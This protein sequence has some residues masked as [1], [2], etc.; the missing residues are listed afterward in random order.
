MLQP[1]SWG[2]SDCSMFADVVQSLTGFD[3][4]ADV[5]GY[6][7]ELSAVRR[8]RATGYATTLSLVEDLFPEID[9]REAKRGDLGYPAEIPH[10]LMSPAVIDGA[11]AYSKG[12]E[13]GVL[14][15]RCLIARAFAV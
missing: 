11:Y 4:I 7:C 3:C 15:S 12:L 14:I 2:V 6:R 9:P 10:R 13:G 5:R 1:F 8:L